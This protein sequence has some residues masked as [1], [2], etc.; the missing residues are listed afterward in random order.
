MQRQD[1]SSSRPRAEDVAEF[2]STPLWKLAGLNEAPVASTPS[3]KA[4]DPSF[5]I[6]SRS[7]VFAAGTK[8][9][10]YDIRTATSFVRKLDDSIRLEKIQNAGVFARSASCFL[11]RARRERLTI[12]EK[13]IVSGLEAIFTYALSS[14]TQM[15]GGLKAE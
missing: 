12:S 15:R 10:N 4:G 2:M 14:L 9:S 3:P 8:S 11:E 1:L 13:R 7:E 5:I 6:M